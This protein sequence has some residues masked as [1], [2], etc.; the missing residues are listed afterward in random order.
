M[1]KRV[2]ADRK[3]LRPFEIFGRERSVLKTVGEL[4]YR[5][6]GILENEIGVYV[7][8]WCS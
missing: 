3:T 1:T 5:V 4:D 2:G 7:P 6:L 8:E